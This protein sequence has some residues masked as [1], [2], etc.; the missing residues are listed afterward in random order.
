[1][2][3]GAGIILH[4]LLIPTEAVALWIMLQHFCCLKKSGSTVS[5]ARYC[6]CMRRRLAT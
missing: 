2:A 6:T 5:V 3:F 4:K 1:M